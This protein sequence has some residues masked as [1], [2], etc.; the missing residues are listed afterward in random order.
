VTTILN[1][2]VHTLGVEPSELY[3]G[4]VPGD[5]VSMLFEQPPADVTPPA[6]RVDR[7]KYLQMINLALAVLGARLLGLIAVLGAVAM[8]GYAVYDPIPWRT[9]TVGAYAAVVLWPIV[10]LYIRRG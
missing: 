7:A 3:D 10:L 4:P 8:F 5:N 9:Y 1:E 2:N 6:P